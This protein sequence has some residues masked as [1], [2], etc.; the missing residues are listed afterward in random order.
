MAT[1]LVPWVDLI[2]YFGGGVTLWGMYSRTMIP[3]RWGAVGGN[4]GFLVFGLLAESYPTLIL[5]AILLPLNVFRAWQMIKLVR[6]IKATSDGA[7]DLDPLIP[8]MKTLKLPAGAELFRK[9]DKPDRM[10]VVKH[11]TVLLV[12]LDVRCGPSDILGEIGAF[13]PDNR[14]TC[15]AVCETDCELYSL[16]YEAMMQLYYQNPRFGMF[17]IRVIVQRLLAN[18]QDAEARAKAIV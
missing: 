16:S 10:L 9:D 5:H 17:L 7:N 12:E 11:G 1:E 8:F 2:G 4:V 6:E 3:L 13:T 18:W 14:R 15:T